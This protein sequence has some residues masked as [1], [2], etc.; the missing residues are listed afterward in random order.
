MHYYT[1]IH[2]YGYRTHEWIKFEIQQIV[3]RKC[4]LFTCSMIKRKHTCYLVLTQLLQ[5]KCKM[6]AT[7]R[8]W[9]VPS[10]CTLIWMKIFDRIL[11]F[12]CKYHFFIYVCTHVRTLELHFPGSLVLS[13][14]LRNFSWR[15]MPAGI[16]FDIPVIFRLVFW[17][18]Y[19]F[20]LLN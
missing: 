11:L 8:Y 16:L 10:G 14:L 5:W 17:Y 1:V 20:L 12:V 9:V 7:L 18:A 15:T 13:P 2:T 6:V 4:E 19:N 3:Q